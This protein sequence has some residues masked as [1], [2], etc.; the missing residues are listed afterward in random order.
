MGGGGVTGPRIVPVYA[1]IRVVQNHKILKN[2]N[3]L[4]SKRDLGC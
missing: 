3:K 4:V 1:R 2:A